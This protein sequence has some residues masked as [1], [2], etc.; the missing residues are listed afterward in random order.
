MGGKINLRKI[1]EKELIDAFTYY[2]LPIT[3]YKIYREYLSKLSKYSVK[4]LN[5]E[6]GYN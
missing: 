4:K 2:S 1:S 6:S 5:Y 3:Y